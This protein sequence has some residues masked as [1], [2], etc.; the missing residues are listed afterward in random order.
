[1]LNSFVEYVKNLIFPYLKIESTSPKIPNGHENDKYLR[2]LRADNSYW[3]YLLLGW[4]IYAITWVLSI[5]IGI[6]VILVASPLFMWL[7]IPVV[8]FAFVKAV[9]LFV[10]MRID[11]ELRWYIITDTSVTVRQGAWTIR[12][13][14]VSYQNIQNVS[15]SQGP[16]ERYFGFANLKIETAGNAG[17]GKHGK[18]SNPNQAILRGIINSQQ[19]RDKILENLR[20]FRNSGLGDPDD[21]EPKQSEE[22]NAN[23]IM[24]LREIEQEA[25]LLHKTV[26]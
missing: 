20:T 21:I 23:R 2:V 22:A 24:L 10:V 17:T 15:V 26:V 14:T 19:I 11:Y 9:V 13:I 7:A 25:I 1:M 6:I 12:E 8:M 18:G 3:S 4:L 5:S 16:L